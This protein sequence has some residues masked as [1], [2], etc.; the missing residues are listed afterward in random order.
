[1]TTRV[2]DLSAEPVAGHQPGI[3]V[4]GAY[5][6]LRPLGK[7]GMATV[8]LAVDSRTGRQVAIKRMLPAVAHDEELRHAFVDEARL[9]VRLRHPAIV[10]TIELGEVTT[11]VGQ[12]SYIVLEL[13]QGRALIELLRCAGRRKVDVPLDVV[14]RTV[15]DAARALDFAHQLVGLDGNKLG[16]VHRDVSPH[17]VFACAD[18]G[19]K[20]LDFG[21][22]KTSDQSHKTRTGLIKG[23]LA[24]LAPEQIRGR[25]VDSRCDVF[26]LGI[27]LYEL[28]VGRPLF[29]GGNDAETL[30]RV[31][32]LDVEPPDS[33]RRDVPPG[34]GAIA[35][36]ALHRDRDRRLP[37]AGAL[38]DAVEAVAEAAGIV[39]TR[40]SVRRFQQELFPSDADGHAEDS[41]LAK[42]TYA[43]LSSSSLRALGSN[44]WLTPPGGV[45]PARLH[46]HS[47]LAVTAAALLVT[48]SAAF[49]TTRVLRHGVLRHREQAANDP[50]GAPA[51][52]AREAVAPAPEPTVTAPV[53]PEPLHVE[54]PKPPGPKP[55]GPK[56]ALA[57]HRVVGHGSLRLAAQPWAEVKVDGKSL[58]I[59]PLRSTEV[60]EGVHTVVL[61]NHELGASVRRKVTVHAGQEAVLVVNLFAEKK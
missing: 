4:L 7:G 31:L 36:R 24:Y 23:K 33:L 57:K 35:L 61:T 5:H 22:A 19:I 10:E 28:L 30:H 20:L 45:P 34:L 11:A 41:A 26:A 43:H 56:L 50:V 60:T 59:T 13:L 3:D 54:P 27:V 6:L 1:M 16:V 51:V 38:A 25:D 49:L 37:T 12:E 55:A 44:P 9:G 15:V 53:V 21:I 40:E 58:G 14:V 52:V 2:P 17:N 32:T 8:W 18:G 48:A 39:A 42:K 29:R 47:R 46:R